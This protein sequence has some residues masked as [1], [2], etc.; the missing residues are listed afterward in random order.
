MR[1]AEESAVPIGAKRALAAAWNALALSDEWIRVTGTGF[2]AEAW[3]RWV[4][5]ATT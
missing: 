2:D 3:R 4:R 5:A 1:Q